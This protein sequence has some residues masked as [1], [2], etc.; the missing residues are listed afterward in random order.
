MKKYLAP[1]AICGLLTFQPAFAEVKTNSD[2]GFST[3][4]VAEV[5][6]SPDE[7]WQRLITPSKW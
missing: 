7:L 3:L 6:A 4:H 2:A 1:V 5:D